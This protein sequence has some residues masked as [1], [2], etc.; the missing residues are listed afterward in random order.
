MLV[1]SGND[2]L[3]DLLT[4]RVGKIVCPSLFFAAKWSQNSIGAKVIPKALRNQ[5]SPKN[6]SPHVI[7]TQDKRLGKEVFGLI[8]REALGGRYVSLPTISERNAFGARLSTN[9]IDAKESTQ[10]QIEK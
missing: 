4:Y 5:R 6:L 9:T 1:L 10:R 3:H 8:P 2:F 7:M